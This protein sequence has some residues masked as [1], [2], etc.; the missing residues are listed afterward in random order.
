MRE[1]S[2]SDTQMSSNVKHRAEYF[3]VLDY[4][5]IPISASIW[6]KNC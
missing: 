5:K 2:A 3:Y 4:Q 1:E 6:N